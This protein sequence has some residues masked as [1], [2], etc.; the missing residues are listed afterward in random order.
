MAED[1]FDLDR[2]LYAQGPVYERVRLELRRGH[3]Q[4]HWIWFV[5]PQLAGLGA[6]PMSEKYAIAS[7]DEAKAYLDHPVLGARLRECVD[8]VNGIEGRSIDDI[9]GHPDNLKFRSSLTLFA[10]AAADN[11]IFTDALHKYYGGVF[12]P[13]TLEQLKDETA[14]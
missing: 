7:L 5:F 3:K 1:P 8:L 11:Q 14:I 12:D 4:S 9:F 2:F 13:M 10:H 6:S